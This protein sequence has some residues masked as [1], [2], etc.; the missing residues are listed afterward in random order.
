MSLTKRHASAAPN[1]A[2]RTT[3]PQRAL[4]PPPRP[5]APW[6]SFG[7]HKAKQRCTNARRD[8]R[9][10]KRRARANTRSDCIAK[11]TVAFTQASAG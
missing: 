10:R 3:A 9:S 7:A 4:H 8:R 2:N 5:R 11:Q 6:P 1:D